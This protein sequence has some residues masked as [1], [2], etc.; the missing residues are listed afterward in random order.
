MNLP[1]CMLA[2]DRKQKCLHKTMDIH[3]AWLPVFITF[4]I[5][6]PVGISNEPPKQRKHNPTDKKSHGKDKQVP[7]P[8]NVHHRGED[9]LEI[10]LASLG[11]ILSRDVDSAIFQN[12]PLSL[13][14]VDEFGRT[15]S[16]IERSAGFFGISIKAHVPR[17]G[18]TLAE[19]S[20]GAQHPVLSR[21]W[22]V[23]LQVQLQVA[24]WQE[25]PHS[26]VVRIDALHLY[27]EVQSKI[28]N[29]RKF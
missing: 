14:I 7:P 25:L 2:F 6:I 28:E 27:W 3:N 9:I 4:V 10:S 22:R 8:L 23:V 29:T 24:S 11:H 17:D 19:C 21:S 16:R 18:G 1:N 26:T 15:K 12:D 5:Q 13:A 20:V